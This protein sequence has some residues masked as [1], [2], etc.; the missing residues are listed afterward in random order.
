MKLG[1]MANLSGELVRDGERITVEQAAAARAEIASL[2]LRFGTTFIASETTIVFEALRGNFR[3]DP[4]GGMR[5]ELQADR[6]EAVRLQLVIGNLSLVGRLVLAG[7]RLR[8]EGNSGALFAESLQV[9]ELSLDREGTKLELGAFEGTGVAVEWS[10][11]GVRVRAANTVM[12]QARVAAPIAPSQPREQ[13]AVP[14]APASSDPLAKVRPYLPLLDGLA[15]Q[16]D[17]DL[18]LDIALPVLGHRRATHKFRLEIVEGTLDYRQLESGLSRLE[19]QLLD[20]S[21]RDDGLVLEVGIP[22]VPTRGKGKPLL[23][24]D[25]QDHD[26]ALAQRDRIRLAKLPDFEKMFGDDSGSDAPANGDSSPS[27]VRELSLGNLVAN[28]HLEHA[29]PPAAAP[30]RRLG[31]LSVRADLHHAVEIQPRNGTAS[32]QIADVDLGAMQIRLGKTTLAFGSVALTAAD[33]EGDFEGMQP[34]GVRARIAGL[35]IADLD[36]DAAKA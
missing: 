12:G 14:S 36:L 28:L 21:M 33:A 32:A 18:G 6:A 15:G 7:A 31:K 22:F 34:R 24:W 23:R 29:S 30:L 25:V 1:E 10:P 4:L 8:I 9:S 16:L 26:L 2:A 35:R 3:R 27:R 5:C 17:V 11:A 13:S 20:F 19:D